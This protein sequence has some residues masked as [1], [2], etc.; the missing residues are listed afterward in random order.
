[1]IRLSNTLK[2]SKLLDENSIKFLDF[3]GTI[4]GARESEDYVF[5]IGKNLERDK[6][7]ELYVNNSNVKNEILE[8]AKE[9]GDIKIKIRINGLVSGDLYYPIHNNN[10]Y[11][12]YNWLKEI[13]ENNKEIFSNP[14][15][16][17]LIEWYKNETENLNSTNTNFK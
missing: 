6:V 4:F 10:I 12:G 13:K 17:K 14:N 2:K 7:F 3:I 11:R 5:L 9:W 1:M 15:K 8:Y 16:K